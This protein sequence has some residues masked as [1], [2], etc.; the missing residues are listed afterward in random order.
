ME[1]VAACGWNGWQFCRGIGGSFGVEYAKAKQLLAEAGYP[2][3]FEAGDLTPIAPFFEVGEA[4]VHYLNAI[5]IRIQMRSMERAAFYTAWKEKK[6]H[7]LV[8]PGAGISGNAAT[9][10]ESFIYSKG[11]YAY[12]GYPDI[13]ALFEQQAK[14]RDTL[15]REALLHRLQALTIERVVFAPVYD[16]RGLMGREH[17]AILTSHRGALY[18]GGKRFPTPFERTHLWDRLRLS[19]LPMRA[20][21]NNGTGCA[22]GSTHALTNGSIPSKSSSVSH[23]PPYRR[24]ATPCGAC[25]RR[26]PEG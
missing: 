9:R 5:G 10:V 19:P 12:G 22:S 6:L 3:G 23:A 8:M 14:E 26:S 11:S 18:N 25:V 16:L 2:N 21:A 15:T 4:I 7:G 13:D 20:Q 24:S 1:A 17:S